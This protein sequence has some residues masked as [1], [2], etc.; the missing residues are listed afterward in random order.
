MK[1]YSVILIVLCCFGMCHAQQIVRS[2]VGSSGGTGKI[3]SGE[4]TFMV[5]QSIGQ[6]S[7]IGTTV[8]GAVTLRQGFIQAPIKVMSIVSEDTTLD[9]TVFPNP[10]ESVLTIQFN[11]VIS[12]E[13]QTILYDMLGRIVYDRMQEGN[14]SIGIDMSDLSTAQYVLL[15]TSGNKQFKANLIKR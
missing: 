7:V 9:A 3:E 6:S 13:V 1:K 14:Q 4:H 2:S 10:V 11:E 8:N 5:Q 12:G 15:V